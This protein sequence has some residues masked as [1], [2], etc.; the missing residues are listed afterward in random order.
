MVAA[1]GD[2]RN[3]VGNEIGFKNALTR[4]ADGV[5]FTVTQADDFATRYTLKNHLPNVEL[6]GFSATVFLDKTTGKHVIAM[7]G[8]EEIGRASCRER[9]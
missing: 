4:Q 2:L 1:Y 5:K 6:N 9:V 8:T 3:V 7:R